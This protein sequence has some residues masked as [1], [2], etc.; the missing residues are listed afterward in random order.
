MKKRFEAVQNASSPSITLHVASLI[1]E[2]NVSAQPSVSF[3]ITEQAFLLF[4]VET[5]RFKTP[6]IVKVHKLGAVRICALC[7]LLL[8]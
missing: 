2:V 4:V 7:A 1:Q 6:S 8:N 3:L 5:L